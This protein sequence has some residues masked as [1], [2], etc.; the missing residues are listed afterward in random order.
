MVET[1][2]LEM[3]LRIKAKKSIAPQFNGYGDVIQHMIKTGSRVLENCK[4]A[5]VTGRF[6]LGKDGTSYIRIDRG[7]FHSMDKNGLLTMDRAIGYGNGLE[8]IVYSLDKKAMHK[9]Y[10]AA[11]KGGV[12]GKDR[13]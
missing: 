6:I 9:S 7:L 12:R 10:A 8:T 4:H 5:I 3:K 13:N 11:T 2:Q 1:V